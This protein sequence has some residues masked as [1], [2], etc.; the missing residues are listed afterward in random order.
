MGR[1]SL[2]G[3]VVAAAVILDSRKCVN[4]LADSKQLSGRRRAY[5]YSQ[6][7][8]NAHSWAVA[9]ASVVEV[10]QLNIFQASLLAMS[11]AVDALDKKPEFVYVDGKHCPKW[12]YPSKAIVKGDSLIPSIAAASIIAKVTRDREMEELDN[13]F[14]GYG[15][16][17]HKGYPTN[18]HLQALKNLG[19]CSIHRR[20]FGPVAKLLR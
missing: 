20:S 19:P 3:D 9:H 1:G 8:E 16:A 5:F 6:I 14:P 12:N 10:D 4:G 15:F 2:A 7:L 11:R 17:Q 18:M 13:I